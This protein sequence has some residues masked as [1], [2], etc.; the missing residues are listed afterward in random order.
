MWKIPKVR[1]R[2]TDTK[3]NRAFVWRRVKKEEKCHQSELNII[4]HMLNSPDS[5]YKTSHKVKVSPSNLGVSQAPRFCMLPNTPTTPTSFIP[6][7]V[8]IPVYADT[9]YSYSYYQ[10]YCSQRTQIFHIDL[11]KKSNKEKRIVYSEIIVA[12]KIQYFY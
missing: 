3:T 5:W 8:T 6:L 11:V 4:S 7:F 2:N 10:K 9:T 12:G 1:P